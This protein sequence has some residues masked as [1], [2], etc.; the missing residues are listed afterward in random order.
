MVNHDIIADFGGFPDDD[1]HTMV[2]EQTMPDRC[3]RMDF[4]TG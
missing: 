2:N 1:P 4:D 3:P